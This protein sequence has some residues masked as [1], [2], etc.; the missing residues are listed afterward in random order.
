MIFNEN[1]C[2][3]LTWII[4]NNVVWALGVLFQV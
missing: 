1:I 2:S 3:N 4:V